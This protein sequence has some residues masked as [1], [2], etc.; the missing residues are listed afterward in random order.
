[1]AEPQGA[2]KVEEKPSAPQGAILV[3]QEEIAPPQNALIS[4]TPELIPEDSVEDVSLGE[5]TRRILLG[6]LRDA[7]Q[8]TIDFASFVN[9]LDPV[10]VVTAVAIN[11]NLAE[12]GDPEAQDLNS[13]L[14][15]GESAYTLPEV[16]EPTSGLGQFGRT[17]FQFLVPY[18]GARK[19]IGGI[20][21]TGEK[22]FK[23]LTQRTGKEVALGATAEQMAFSPDEARLSNLIQ[24]GPL[25][26]PLAEYLAADP[27]DAEATQRFKMAI[28]GSLVALPIEAVFRVAGKIR[29]QNKVQK[30]IDEVEPSII[31]TSTN[32]EKA[33]KETIQ[34]YETTP[35]VKTID[36]ANKERQQIKANEKKDP[37]KFKRGKEGLGNATV[38]T[39]RFNFFRSDDGGV[40]VTTKDKRTPEEVNS[41][42]EAEQMVAS[43]QQR[44]I[45]VDKLRKELENETIN[46]PV[47]IVENL[48]EARRYVELTYVNKNNL[49]KLLNPKEPKVQKVSNLMRG[50]FHSKDYGIADLFGE[51]NPKNIGIQFFN[52]KKRPGDAFE[53]LAEKLREAGFTPDEV[54]GYLPTFSKAR[55]SQIVSD[56]EVL[57]EFQV[58]YGQYQQAQELAQKQIDLLTENGYNPY[59]MTNTDVTRALKNIDEKKY[60]DDILQDQA[61]REVL[62]QQYADEYEQMVNARANRVSREAVESDIIDVNSNVAKTIREFGDGEPP[63][64]GSQG[65]NKPPIGGPEKAGNI[66]LDKIL[67]PDDVL[68]V[69][70]QTAARNNDFSAS[71][72]VVRF[73]KDGENLKALAEQLGMKPD[74]LLLR[75]LGQAFNSE[76]IHAAR[77]LLDEAAANVAELARKVSDPAQVTDAMRVDFEKALARFASIQEQ[78]AGITAEAGR[79][80]RAFRESVGPAERQSK[81][82]SDYLSGV[83]TRGNIDETA[84]AITQLDSNAG[85]AQ[86]ARS[87]FIGKAKDAVQEFW[88]N[89]LLSAPATHFVN[90]ISNMLTAALRPAEYFLAATIGKLRGGNDVVSFGEVGARLVGTVYGSLEGLRAMGK[91][92]LKGEIDDPLTKLELQRPRAINVPILGDIIRLPGTALTAEDAFFKTIGQQQ[93]YFGRAMIQAQKEGKGIKRAYELLK[94]KSQ[95]GETVRLKAIDAGRYTTFTKPLEGIFKNYQSWVAKHP[96]M[97]YLTPFVR[98]PVNIV[99]YAFDR[100]PTALFFGK[101]KEAM[102]AGG[103]ARDEALGK[104][105]LGSAIMM[106]VATLSQNGLITGRGPSNPRERSQLMETGWQPYSIKHGDKYLSYNRFEPVGILFGITADLTEAYKYTQTKEFKESEEQLNEV[107]ALLM[108]SVSQ[109]LI[110]KTFLTGLSGAVEVISDPD[111]YGDK[112][113]ERFVGSWVPTVGFYQRKVD[114]PMVRD[115]RSIMDSVINRTPELFGN[116]FNVSTSSDLPLKR[117][118]FGETRTYKKTPF[119]IKDTIF[120]VPINESQIENDVVFNEFNRLDYFPSMPKRKFMDINLTTEQYNDLLAQ[121][122]QLGAKQKLEQIISSPNY[123]N[124]GDYAKLMVLEKS[125][126]S[127]QEAARTLFLTNNPQ[128]LIESRRKKLQEIKK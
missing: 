74:N 91:V 16:E 43:Q 5:S 110:N 123:Q 13:L 65:A 105:A 117:N 119:G 127:Y 98:T 27:N 87:N 69:I 95:L 7:A 38:G 37:I 67:E 103:R 31:D 72:R 96:A 92:L 62:A 76:Q 128:I 4:K 32:I 122:E 81:F 36:E 77:M 19:I 35:G 94:D 12:Q 28:E 23:Y 14:K 121:M 82:I 18:G 80:L 88:I 49:P 73:G 93:E 1:M 86:F 104:V 106:G 26:N 17:L 115:A 107:A 58:P 63:I 15:L 20:K 6:G 52:N 29:A 46:R 41:Q 25:A 112:F 33:R 54:S 108:G 114:D 64:G 125:M 57:P 9:K 3:P 102:K 60:A 44:Q 120:V 30:E 24:S 61:D 11:A 84:R 2:I 22:T 89:A 109:N 39:R 116:V 83:K 34:T 71:R 48:D 75:K 124:Q 42:I 50:L 8:G 40:E 100:F 70:R 97:R 68:D 118:I 111:R 66:R 59:R 45:D 85:I 99:N 90:I 10:N 51:T 101:T 79:A 113:V 126:R 47:T 55:I 21:D 78:V 53:R 56:N